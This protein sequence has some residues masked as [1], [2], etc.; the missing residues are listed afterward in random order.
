MRLRIGS[1]K[2]GYRTQSEGP[3]L[4]P[5]DGFYEWKAIGK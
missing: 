4:I 5:V 3:D 2:S 1:E